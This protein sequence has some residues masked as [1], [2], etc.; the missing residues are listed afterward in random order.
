MYSCN[1]INK[2]ISFIMIPPKIISVSGLRTT[3]MAPAENNEC[4]FIPIP[5][6]LIQGLDIQGQQA[7]DLKYRIR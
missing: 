5:C 3:I 4:F 7:I 1:L 6:S 2:A